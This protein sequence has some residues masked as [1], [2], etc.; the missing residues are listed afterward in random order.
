MYDYWELTIKFEAHAEEN[1][2]CKKKI[3]YM[4]AVDLNGFNCFYASILILTNMMWQDEVKMHLHV[5]W[6]TLIILG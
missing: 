2:E 5:E 1:A 4:F 3:W 6:L